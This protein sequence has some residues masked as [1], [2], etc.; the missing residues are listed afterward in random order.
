MTIFD[1]IFRKKG[2]SD[3]PEQPVEASQPIIDKASFVEERHPDEILGK[4][5]GTAPVSEKILLQD[6][7]DRD[8]ASMGAR[9]GYEY[10]ELSYLTEGQEL[11]KAQFRLVCQ[12]AFYEIDDAYADWS[13]QASPEMEELMPEVYEQVQAA[14]T[15]LDKQRSIL[16]Q[17]LDLIA[18]GEGLIEES[19]LQYQAGFKKG[20]SL[21][22]EEKLISKDFKLFTS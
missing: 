19:L 10:H 20:F 7:L 15:R 13:A 2:S 18:M 9:D 22:M 6:L 3:T 4:E 12:K 14:I 11:I 17:Q 16:Q 21:F 1:R 5:A 8:Y